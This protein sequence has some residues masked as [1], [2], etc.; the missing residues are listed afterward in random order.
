MKIARTAPAY[1]QRMSDKLRFGA[2][3][4]LPVDVPKSPYLILGQGGGPG[5]IPNGGLGR[6]DVV[7][8][9]QDLAGSVLEA[10]GSSGTGSHGVDADCRGTL[11]NLTRLYPAPRF[12]S[13][14]RPAREVGLDTVMASAVSGLSR[15]LG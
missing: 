12:R 9:P 7:L 4:R 14:Q 8:G 10:L 15:G 11:C 3:P 6:Q 1:L 13:E 2:I 5:R